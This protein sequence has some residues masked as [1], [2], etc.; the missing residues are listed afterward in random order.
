MTSANGRLGILQNYDG[1]GNGDVYI[2][3]YVSKA[4]TLRV[5]QAFL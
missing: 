1:E 3:D 4:T 2:I 5:H